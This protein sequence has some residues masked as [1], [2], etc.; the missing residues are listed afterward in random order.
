[1]AVYVSLRSCCMQDRNEVT[2]PLHNRLRSAHTCHL[3][4]LRRFEFD[5]SLLRYPCQQAV[6]SKA[7][8]SMQTSASCQY[9]WLTLVALRDRLFET[10]TPLPDTN[11]LPMHQS[12]CHHVLLSLHG[13][14]AFRWASLCHCLAPCQASISCCQGMLEHDG[15]MGAVGQGW[16]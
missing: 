8:K 9:L 14:N 3:H 10:Q 12:A 11:D 4:V 7:T 13:E 2:L 1:M 16:S 15:V 6:K 5:S